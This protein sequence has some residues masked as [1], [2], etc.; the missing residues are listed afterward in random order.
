MFSAILLFLCASLICS[1]PILREY[2]AWADH[3][4]LREAVTD[5]DQSKFFKCLS[6]NAILMSKCSEE[7]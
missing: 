2:F 4:V 7:M 1:L 5:L 6:K 3:L